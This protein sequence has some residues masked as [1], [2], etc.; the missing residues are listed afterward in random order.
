MGRMV[1]GASR[2]PGLPPPLLGLRASHCFHFHAPTCWAGSQAGR[3]EGRQGQAGMHAC[4]GAG[5]G[6][7]GPTYAAAV[8]GLVR[9]VCVHRLVLGA[10][11]DS[12]SYRHHG[13]NGGYLLCT[14]AR[15]QSL[16]AAGEGGDVW[17]ISDWLHSCECLLQIGTHLRWQPVWSREASADGQFDQGNVGPSTTPARLGSACPAASSAPGQQHPSNPLTH[18]T[19]HTSRSG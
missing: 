12:P 8:E 10:I 7:R 15:G 11:E 18:R 19:P 4:R 17:C 14:P 16:G 3:E 6:R 1:A 13:S 9:V 5:R 2:W